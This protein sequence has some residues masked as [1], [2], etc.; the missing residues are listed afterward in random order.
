[1]KHI[2]NLI[3]EITDR[4]ALNSAVKAFLSL[5]ETWQTIIIEDLERTPKYDSADIVGSLKQILITSIAFRSIMLF[6]IKKSGNKKAMA[7]FNKFRAQY[8][9]SPGIEIEGDIEGGL[10]IVHNCCVI[11]VEH[12]GKNL[13]VG[14]FVVIGKSH[15]SAPSIGNNV[16][17][18]ANSTVI[19]GIK[20][21][22]N[23]LVGAASF[24]RQDIAAGHVV[25]GNPLKII[26]TN[27]GSV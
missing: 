21:G 18:C 5:D 10:R 22:D 27:K 4:S 2:P 20:I 23:S 15:N 7:Y 13:S 24:V 1:M 16:T 9:D 26:R 6:R 11:C 19:G 12:A 8:P 14:P 3:K 17:I 25:G